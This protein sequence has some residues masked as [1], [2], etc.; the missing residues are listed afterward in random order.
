MAI[1]IFRRARG[2]MV[3]FP[4]LKLSLAKI[5]EGCGRPEFLTCN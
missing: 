4:F 3:F 5:A 1:V 2:L